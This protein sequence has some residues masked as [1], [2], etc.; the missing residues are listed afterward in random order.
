V[1]A[2]RDLANY[3]DPAIQP[4]DPRAIMRRRMQDV[5]AAATSQ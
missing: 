2:L 3:V 5:P 4:A 1:I